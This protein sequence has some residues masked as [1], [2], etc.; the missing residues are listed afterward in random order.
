MRQAKLA[1]YRAAWTD[2]DITY[3]TLVQQYLVT[4]K[5]YD[6]TVLHTEYVDR[7]EDVEDPVTAGTIATPTRESTVSTVYTYNGWDGDLTAIIAPRTLTAKY[8][9]TPR[10]YTVKWYSTVGIVMDTQTVDYG[11]EAIYAGETPERTDEEAQAIY[12]LFKGWDKSTGY[13]KG[14][15]EVWAV[16]E[17][18]ELPNTGTQLKDMNAAQINAV[19]KSG[20]AANYFSLKDRVAITLGFNPAYSNVEYIEATN[21]AIFLC[22]PAPIICAMITCA[23]LEN[24]IARKVRKLAMSPPTETAEIPVFPITR[25]TIIMSIIL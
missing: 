23:A 11:S 19:I 13:I 15:T 16:W 1:A 25:P 22:S 2:L 20:N 10:K 9:E 12:Y 18:G 14:D 6:G 4:F 3:Q 17:R 5:N 7:N 24:P 21:F 8:T